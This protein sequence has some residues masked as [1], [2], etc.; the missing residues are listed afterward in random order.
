MSYESK[1]SFVSRIE[2]IR[3][4]LSKFSDR[5]SGVERF[6]AL[7]SWRALPGRDAPAPPV[8]VHGAADGRPAVVERIAPDVGS[9]V[10]RGA[11]FRPVGPTRIPFAAR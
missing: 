4:K 11:P 8:T 9:L 6:T 2:F 1:L 3:S 7:G 5:V 10:H